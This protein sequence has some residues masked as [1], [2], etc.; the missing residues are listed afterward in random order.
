MEHSRPKSQLGGPRSQ[1]EGSWNYLGA[2]GKEDQNTVNNIFHFC[3]SSYF[4]YFL[5]LCIRD[6]LSTYFLSDFFS[7]IF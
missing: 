4:W 6:L 5:F 1:L 2:V 7:V 3:F